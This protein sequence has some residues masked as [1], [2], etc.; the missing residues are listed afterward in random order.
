MKGV[1]LFFFSKA[2][3]VKTPCPS[4]SFH[5]FYFSG[6]VPRK[7]PHSFLSPCSWPR[8][9]QRQRAEAVVACCRALLDAQKWYSVSVCG[10]FV[11]L[12]F[13]CTAIRTKP[14]VF[15]QHGDDFPLLFGLTPW[16]EADNPFFV[17]PVSCL[18]FLILLFLRG[19]ILM[20]LLQKPLNLERAPWAFVRSWTNNRSLYKATL[21]LNAEWSWW[22]MLNLMTAY[23]IKEVW[24]VTSLRKEWSS[25]HS[26]WTMG[27]VYKNTLG[28][29]G[30]I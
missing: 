7:P 3:A 28:P 29:T 26:I 8:D 21:L 14:G 30:T 1:F 20:L 23:V 16:V 6:R 11:S 15:K 27:E 18:C 4:Q 2:H 19:L 22:L 9:A 24:C 17:Q 12:L 13:H 5:L 25:F 10:G